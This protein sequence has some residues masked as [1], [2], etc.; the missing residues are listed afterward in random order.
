M[1]IISFLLFILFYIKVTAQAFIPGD[2]AGA[3]DTTSVS[4]NSITLEPGTSLQL[5]AVVSNQCL[6]KFSIVKKSSCDTLIPTSL[7]LFLK[8]I[9]ERNAGKKQL[10]INFCVMQ[11]EDTHSSIMIIYNGLGHT[12]VYSA[13]TRKCGVGFYRE[14]ETGVLQ[15]QLSEMETWAY[16]VC[17]LKLMDFCIINN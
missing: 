6:I 17:N 3:Y 8:Q 16:P 5:K 2:S 9:G 13:F 10:E 12:F 14:V 15:Q 11:I 4:N 7:P 1:R